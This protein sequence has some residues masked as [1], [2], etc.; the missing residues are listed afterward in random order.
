MDWPFSETQRIFRRSV[1]KFVNEELNPQVD[2]WEA[3]GIVPK[4]VFRRMGELGFLGIRAPERYGGAEADIWSTVVFCEEMGRCRSRGLTMGS[5]VQTDMTAPY[6]IDFG[7][8]ALKARYLPPMISG[9]KIASIVLTEPGGG[10][11]LARMRTVA[12]RQG[13]HYSLTGAKVF[14]TNALNADLFF[15]AAKTAL[16]QG[17]RGISMLIVERDTPGFTIEPMKQKLGMHGSDTGELTFENAPVPAENLIGEENRGFYYI[18]RSLMNERFV[19]CAA[20]TSSAQ[21][22]LEDA[23]QYA[24]DRELFGQ[25]LSEFQVTRHRLAQLQTKLEAARQ[26]VYYAAQQQAAGED[27]STTVAMCKAFCADVA[28]ETS[29]ACLQLHGGYG[30]IEEYD[31]ARFYRDIRLW[32][33]GGGSTETMYEIIAKRMG[34]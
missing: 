9:E 34:I 12:K 14:I 5:L 2:E 6:L 18:L 22:A 4:E 33:I 16:E 30:Y 20:M 11:D 27:W 3:Q 31:I 19:A 21:Q 25:K 15:V 1:R 8:E 7:S 10:S 17:H 23:I 26:L 32:K 28:V 13:D 24:Q 29:D